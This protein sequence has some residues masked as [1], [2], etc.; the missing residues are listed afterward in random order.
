MGLIDKKGRIFGKVN[1]VD[2]A[3]LMI[4]LLMVFGGV[5]KFSQISNTTQD[6]TEEISVTIEVKDI[7][8]GLVEAITE[9]DILLDSVRGSE[10]GEVLSKSSV[11]P[12]QELVI[13]KD[14]K[15]E[16]KSIPGK[17]DV[18]LELKSPALVT[19]EGIL[20]GRKPM[21]IGSET[22]LK[23]DLYVFDC[24]VINIVK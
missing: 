7:G 22:R 6:Y 23:S 13:G 20:I 4:V 14:G 11:E 18:V 17:Y 19:E 21:Y 16:F 2:F 24:D 5:Y 10:F 9:G 12:H 1:I 8:S 3:V 15:V